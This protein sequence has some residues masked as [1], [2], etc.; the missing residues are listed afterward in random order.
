MYH[1][2]FFLVEEVTSVVVIAVGAVVVAEV[3]V[4]VVA[5][6]IF[7]PP[8]EMRGRGRSRSREYILFPPRSGGDLE[9]ATGKVTGFLAL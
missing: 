7:L 6:G 8:P 5:M 2:S 9:L 4:G 1:N 3:A